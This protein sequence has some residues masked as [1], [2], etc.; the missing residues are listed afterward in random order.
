MSMQQSRI[1]WRNL[2]PRPGDEML[3]EER[4][5]MLTMVEDTSPGCTTR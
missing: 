1:R 3:D 5:T 4:S 2:R